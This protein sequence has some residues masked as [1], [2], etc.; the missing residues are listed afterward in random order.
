LLNQVES[1]LSVDKASASLLWKDGSTTLAIGTEIGSYRIEGVLGSGGMGVVY[2][3][4]DTRLNRPVAVKVL[5]EEIASPAARRRFQREAQA[6][7]S[8]NH[9]HILTVHDAGEFEERQ[10]LVTEFVDGGTLREWIKQETRDWRQTVELLVGVADGLA[11]AHAAGILH[12]D[13]KPD[14]ILVARNGYAKLADF[15]LAKLQEPPP[16]DASRTRT[17]HTGAGVILGTVPYMSPEQASGKSIDFRSDIFSFGVVLYEAVAGSRPFTGSNERAVLHA[18]VNDSPVPLPRDLPLQL[19]VAVEK[20][21]EK[22]PVSRY[23]SARELVVDLRRL[24]RQSGEPI[25]AAS[26]RT[27]RVRGRFVLAAAAVGIT[28]SAMAA[29]YFLWRAP[30]ARTEWIQITSFGDSATSPSLS[31]DGR[32]LA[33]IRGPSTFFGPGDIYVKLLPDGEPAPLTHDRTNKMSPAIAPDGSRI[34]Y[35]VVDENFAWD[36]FVVP[37]LGGEP[38]R[39]LPNSE[40]LTWIGPRSV[41]FSE[42]KSGAHMVIATAEENRAKERDVF[43]PSHERGMGHRSYLS[44]GGKSVLVVEMGGDGGWLRCRVVPFDGTSAGRQVG[45][46]GSG[47]TYAAWSPDGEWMYL[48]SNAGGAGYH[49]WRQRLKGGDPQQ[50][51]FGPTEQEGI[52]IMPDGRSLI[53]SVGLGQKSIWLHGPQGERQMTSEETASWPV[54]SHD[55]TTLYYTSKTSDFWPSGELWRMDMADGHREQLVAGFSVTGYDVSPDDKRVVFA[56]P[57]AGGHSRMWIAPLDHR[58]APRQLPGTDLCSLSSA[59][60]AAWGS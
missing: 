30:A 51:T 35:T 55:G 38:R 43:V 1:L 26:G 42:I 28:A 44:P 46:R 22:D 27:A 45:P 54:F 2:R 60:M 32:V 24:L 14:N 37:L 50:L 13:I 6:A 56:V 48:N 8:L 49:I 29:G 40:G 18:I 47:C 31:A 59:P 15:G 57:D 25:T 20:A 12:R 19:V 53:S 3:A 58:T 39:L 10:Y 36:T 5:A 21:M 9:P 7:S 34:A 33:F 17:E 41:L 4:M 11:A 16:S 52:A 23:Q